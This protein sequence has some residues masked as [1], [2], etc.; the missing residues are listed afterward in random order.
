[1]GREGNDRL[2]FDRRV[3]AIVPRLPPSEARVATFFAAHKDVVVLNSAALIAEAAGTSDATVVRTARSLGYTGLPDLREDLLAELTGASS[4]SRLLSRTL[5]AT[6]GEPAAI[7]HHLLDLHEDGVGALRRPDLAEAFADA[8]ELI[9]SA[10]TR[11]VFGIGP[12]GCIADYV[13][14]QFNR[15]GLRTMAMTSAGVGMADK[16][17]WVASG[18]VVLML[19]YAP[20]YREVEVLLDHAAEVGAKVVLISDSLGPLIGSRVE[21]VLYVPRGRSDHLAL[22]GATL[23][24]IEALTLGLAARNRAGAVASLDALSRLRGQVDRNWLKRG[25]RRP[26]GAG[27]TNDRS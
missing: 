7:L 5:D 8:V 2:P 6:T 14:L 24:L 22:H 9:G 18:D 13:A 10:P 4:P 23:V 16:L 19:A 1:M 21:T 17:A 20:V 26:A 27:E 12:S 11:H 3:E 25:T 15:I